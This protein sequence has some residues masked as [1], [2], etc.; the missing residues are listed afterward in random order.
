MENLNCNYCDKHFNFR[1]IHDKHVV[2]C[3]YLYQSRSQ[4]HHEIESIEN[5]P[6]QQELFNLVQS[7]SLQCKILTEKVAKLETKNT[8]RVKSNVNAFLQNSPIPK[9]LFDVWIKKMKISSKNLEEIFEN[10]LT[11][12]MKSCLSDRI[13][14]EGLTNIPIRAFKE[15]S[16][17]LYIY[18]D[19]EN[20]KKE[21]NQNTWIMCPKEKISLI[22]DEINNDVV[23]AFCDWQ[24]NL[25]ELN[26]DQQIACSIKISGS[27]IKKDKQI[28]DIK[29]HILH[30]IQVSLV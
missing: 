23:R 28:N 17:V 10:D 12:G 19:D 11:Y 6:S 2:V 5:L 16:G 25:V 22:I 14:N 18:T 21:Q 29:A 15:K 24:S 8:Y 3:E 26:Y 30:M 27:K 13:S 9:E 4:R 1:E 20:E 7:L